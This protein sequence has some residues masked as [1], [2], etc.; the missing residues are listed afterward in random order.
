MCGR[1]VHGSWS[2]QNASHCAAQRHGL[3]SEKL[4]A[5]CIYSQVRNIKLQEEKG[6]VET[7]HQRW[8]EEE[9]GGSSSKALLEAIPPSSH[10]FVI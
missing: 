5:S 1:W 7:E 3:T 6:W 8:E 4:T 2:H 9:C 10:F